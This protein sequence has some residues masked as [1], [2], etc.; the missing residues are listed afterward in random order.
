MRKNRTYLGLIMILLLC[1]L[2][3]QLTAQQEEES[4]EFNPDKKY[5]IQQLKEDFILL[6]TALE[7][8]H[9]GLSY[10]STKEEMDNL[11]DGVSKKLNHPMTEPEFYRHL[12]FLIAGINDGHTEIMHSPEYDA[13]LSSEAILMPFKLLFINGKAYLFRN[14][15]PDEDFVLGGEVLAINDRPMP[16]IVGDMLE[17]IP[18]DGHIQTSKYKNLQSTVYFGR[19]YSLLYGMTTSFRIA[20]NSPEGGRRKEMKVKGLNAA[21]LNRIYQER[22]PEVAK[23]LP[24]AELEYKGDT[25]ILTVRTFSDRPFRNAKISYLAYMQKAFKEISEKGIR[26]LIIDLRDN[27]GG[28]DL[29]GKIL[30][31]YLMDKPF[32]FYKYLGVNTDEL[33]FLQYTDSPD[34]GRKLK[35]WAKKNEKGTFYLQEHPN[36]GEQ[37]PMQPSFSGKVY[38][39]INGGSFSGSGECTSV[40]H[41]HKRAVFIGEECGAGYYGNTSGF[42]PIL[43][44]PNA[45]LRIGIPMSRYVMAVSDYPYPDRGIIPDYPF[46]RTIEDYLNGKD[47]ELEFVLDLIKKQD[48]TE[49]R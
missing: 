8:A 33:S 12:A 23:G 37:K 20:F 7:E 30:V 36:L 28:M 32:M 45:R 2:G 38:M 43:T 47:T 27:G 5:S 3:K 10:Y 4:E 25:A 39:L 19:L 48:K 22:Y 26:H 24:P 11:F 49:T 35:S 34:L 18:S 14:Y 42:G 13:Y 17:L 44:L 15:S 29:N 16:V 21:E 1:F 41:Y 9:A 46:T 6:R 40:L 31:A